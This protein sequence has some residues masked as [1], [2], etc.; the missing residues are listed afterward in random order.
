LGVDEGL[1][2]LLGESSKFLAWSIGEMAHAPNGTAVDLFLDLRIAVSHRKRG[3]RRR[4][5]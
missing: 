2:K 1:L 4:T 5:A 3:H